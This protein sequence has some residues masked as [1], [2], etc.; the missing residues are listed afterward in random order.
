[1]YIYTYIQM[2]IASGLPLSS[3]TPPGT[4]PIPGM[5]PFHLPPTPGIDEWTPT[6]LLPGI[7][8]ENDMDKSQHP[9]RGNDVVKEV[10]KD[11]SS[12]SG[13]SEHTQGV[14]NNKS[15]HVESNTT[16]VKSSLATAK[17]S[18]VTAIPA[19]LVTTTSSD[20]TTDV[21]RYIFIN[22]YIYVTTYT[23]TCAY[24]YLKL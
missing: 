8:E 1:M 7:D 6:G 20:I 10:V 23:F 2:Y 18:L 3:P 22:V 17:T 9:N 11:R 21:S 5:D 13:V 24:T 12:E 15:I 14:S 16:P 19:T 4:G